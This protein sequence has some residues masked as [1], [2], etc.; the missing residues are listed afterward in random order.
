M[1]PPGSDS[2]P[3]GPVDGPRKKVLAPGVTFEVE[4]LPGGLRH[5]RGWHRLGIVSSADNSAR[6]ELAREVQ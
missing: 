3:V 4:V 6:R 1:W 5:L 2:L